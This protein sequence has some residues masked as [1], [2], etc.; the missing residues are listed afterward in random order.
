MPKLAG[1]EAQA[2]AAKYRH[3]GIYYY[4]L[5]SL[6]T[7]ARRSLRRWSGCRYSPSTSLPGART[8]LSCSFAFRR[9]TSKATAT[10]SRTAT[11]AAFPRPLQPKTEDQLAC[12]GSIFGRRQG[13]R[14]QAPLTHNRSSAARL[15]HQLMISVG[16]RHMGERTSAPWPFRGH[17]AGPA[18]RM[19]GPREPPRGEFFGTYLAQLPD[20]RGSPPLGGGGPDPVSWHP[21]W[22]ADVLLLAAGRFCV[23]AGCTGG[24]RHRSPT[25]PG[26]VR[27]TG[28]DLRFLVAGPGF[29]PGKTVVGDFT[30]RVRYCPDLGE[31]HSNAPF[32]HVFDTMAPYGP[33]SLAAWQ[34]VYRSCPGT[35][36]R[37]RMPPGTGSVHVRSGLS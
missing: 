4:T 11:S 21:G 24:V 19:P 8:A 12:R 16:A 13:V 22:S 36:G 3:C 5:R 29:E 30:D 34:L 17:P 15:S 2:A 23:R 32:W 7:G 14:I 20:L 10:G 6:R 35:Y 18:P 26:P 25:P 1:R 28:L 33:H 31:H 27:G 37:T 9:Y